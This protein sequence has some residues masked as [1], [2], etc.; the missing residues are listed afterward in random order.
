MILDSATAHISP[1]V[2]YVF[3]VVGIQYA[4]IPGSL[5]ILIQAIDVA[6]VALYREHH[7]ALYKQLVEGG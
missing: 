3:R 2:L 4:V 1:V 6:L 5:T 7:Y